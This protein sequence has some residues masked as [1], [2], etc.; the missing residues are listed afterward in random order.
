[1]NTFIETVYPTLGYKAPR[2]YKTLTSLVRDYVLSRLSVTFTS[3][4]LQLTIVYFDASCRTTCERRAL[5]TS[6][7]DTGHLKRAKAGY[8]HDTLERLVC[9]HNTL[10][11]MML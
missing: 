10:I 6:D 4:T 3:R 8:G 5:S 7:M 9:V 11:V 1:M 2:K